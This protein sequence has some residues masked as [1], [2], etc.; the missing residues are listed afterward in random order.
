MGGKEKEEAVKM[1]FGW[2]NKKTRK[3]LVLVVSI[4]KKIDFVSSFKPTNKQAK[5]KA[6]RRP[7]W[8]SIAERH[9]KIDSLD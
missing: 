2:N 7:L 4:G 8:G 5:L 3:N 9:A 6:C 1:A